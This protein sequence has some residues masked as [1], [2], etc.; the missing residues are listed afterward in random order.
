MEPAGEFARGE[1]PS[2]IVKGFI[3]R[4]E[5]VVVYGD[6]ASG[7]S[8][9]CLDVM[10]AI[11]RGIS[12]RGLRTKK[13]RVIYIAAEGGG[14]FRKRLIAY[15]IH[16]G[17]ELDTIDLG[18]IN[19]APNFLQKIQ[20]NFKYFLVDEFQ[21]VNSIQNKIFLKLDFLN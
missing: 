8:F 20:S 12:W 10:A 16:H 21:D 2:W 18:I 11:A 15:S 17:V 4:A 3:P 1:S 13:G 6:S 14:G 9:L 19:A 5:L 7:K